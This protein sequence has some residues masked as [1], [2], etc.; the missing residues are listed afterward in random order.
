MS[1]KRIIFAFDSNR[2]DNFDVIPQGHR[3]EDY[4]FIFTKSPEIQLT[5]KG[6]VTNFDIL[7]TDGEKEM[8]GINNTLLLKQHQYKIMKRLSKPEQIARQLIYKDNH[9]GLTVNMIV[10]RS[11]YCDN[12]TTLKHI[13]PDAN[14]CVIKP[15]HGARGIGQFKINTERMPIRVVIDLL[16]KTR[17]NTTGSP[18]T[19]YILE[20]LKDWADYFTYSTSGENYENEGIGIL[21]SQR[22]LVQEH[23]DNIEKEYRI[24]TDYKGNL[25]Y[26]QERKF[27]FDDK[28][29]YQQAIGSVIEPDWVHSKPTSLDK[30][31]NLDE[32]ENFIKTVV[33]PLQSVDLFITKEGKW[34]IFEWCNQFGT[35]GIPSHI[36]MKLHEE[37]LLDLATEIK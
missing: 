8:F 4:E 10:P 9:P 14:S 13:F 3:V 27:K 20:S 28:N 23:V 21:L 18:D 30:T 19:K 16:E 5:G 7:I 22:F 33:G 37:F 12:Y 15:I 35:M 31:D 24:I 26:V 32:I 25:A 1:D 6:I 17:K 11:F 29:Y 36:V 2:I 34:G